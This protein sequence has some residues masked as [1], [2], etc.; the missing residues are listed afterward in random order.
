MEEVNYS[1][2]EA[3]IEHF[4]DKS[5]ARKTYHFLRTSLQISK[6]QKVYQVTG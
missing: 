3:L 4:K 6:Y 2:L 1:P 5:Q